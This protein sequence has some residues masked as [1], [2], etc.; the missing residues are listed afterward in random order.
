[1]GAESCLTS[2]ELAKKVEAVL[3]GPVFVSASEAELVIEG[4]VN[5]K[6]GGGFEARLMVIDG[7]GRWLGS[8]DIS[9]DQLD[10]SAL[11]EALTL[12]IAVTINPQSGLAGGSILSPEMAATLDDLFSRDAAEVAASEQAA[13]AREE[14][15]NPD[16]AQS[17]LKRERLALEPAA[18]RSNIA[19]HPYRGLRA[20]E[21]HSH[22]YFGAAA[23]VGIGLQPPIAP[24][25]SAEVAYES[26]KLL[27][28]GLRGA[29]SVSTR[30]RSG[31]D[32]S[33]YASFNVLSLTP[34]ICPFS[35]SREPHI[36]SG[37]AGV[38]VGAI[39]AKPHGFTV[40]NQKTSQFLLNP[41]FEFRIKWKVHEYI[42][43]RLGVAAILPLIQH[44]F[45]YRSNAGERSEL[46]RMGQIALGADLGFEV[47]Y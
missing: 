9:V 37:C 36:I 22:V 26:N 25:F 29:L 41:I 3:R 35:M 43:P 6:K 5:P 18:D 47:K 32:A 8:R 40:K 38:M 24:G 34:L 7:S 44:S 10:C 1:V 27:R 11:D 42:S 45:S 28:L 39:Q 12:V 14:T 21:T 4:Y 13:T 20:V 17:R 46:F 2:V 19:S 31:T 33:Q 16:A 23:T 30:E 15:N